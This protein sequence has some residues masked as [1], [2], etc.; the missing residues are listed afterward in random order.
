MSLEIKTKPSELNNSWFFCLFYFV[1]NIPYE[2]A[3]RVQQVMRE[4]NLQIIL[5]ESAKP[6]KIKPKIKPI[7]IFKLKCSPVIEKS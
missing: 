5:L 2:Y 6:L 7:S 4:F 1:F 3:Q